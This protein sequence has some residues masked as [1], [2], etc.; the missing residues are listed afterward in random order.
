M[1]FLTC[2]TVLLVEKRKMRNNVKWEADSWS[3]KEREKDVNKITLMFK[4]SSS[5]QN[6]SF[7]LGWGCSYFIKSQQLTEPAMFF[8]CLILNVNSPLFNFSSFF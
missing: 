1:S 2:K 3:E 4:F 8:K 7:N 5:S 6:Y